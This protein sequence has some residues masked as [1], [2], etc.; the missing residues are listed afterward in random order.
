M[1]YTALEQAIKENCSDVHISTEGIAFRKRKAIEIYS[2]EM[3]SNDS[4]GGFLSDNLGKDVYKKCNERLDDQLDFDFSFVF[5]GRR[6]RANISKYMGGYTLA[7]RLLSDKIETI[8]SLNLPKALHKIKDFS[9]G[10]VLVTGA[11]GSGKST[12]L[13]A[14]LEEINQNKPVNIITIEDPVEYVYEPKKLVLY[15]RMSAGMLQVSMMQLYLQCV[16]TLMLFL[17]VR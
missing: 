15:K 2:E 4:I 7:C 3:I 14:V 1:I 11:T 8:E 5:S 10:L 17:L 12:T 9:S 6:W 13:A 16:R